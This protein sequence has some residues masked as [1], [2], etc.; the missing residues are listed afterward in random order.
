MF[1]KVLR[2][3]LFDLK[4]ISNR[5]SFIQGTFTSKASDTKLFFLYFFL[6][7]SNVHL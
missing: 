7:K 2:Q 3:R 6:F 1:G 4:E 5:Y